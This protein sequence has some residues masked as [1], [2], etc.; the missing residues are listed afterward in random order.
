MGNRAMAKGMSGRTSPWIVA[1]R[2]SR[3]DRPENTRAAF[4]RA[5]SFPI[6]GIELDVQMTKDRVPV[7]FHDRTL[8]KIMEG[9]KRL[10]DFSY[11]ELASLDWGQ[12][13]SRK[14][15]G[16]PLLTLEKALQLY[17]KKTRLFIEIKSRDRDR[18]SGRS[19]VL[20]SRVL[21]LI[22]K[23]VPRKYLKNI[24][25]LSFDSEVLS[26][27]QVKSPR[28]NYV[29]NLNE[30]VSLSGRR[31]LD[32]ETLHAVCVPIR[33]LTPRFTESAHR[34]GLAVMTYACNIP[35]QVNKALALNPDVIMTDK[36]GWLV[37]YLLAQGLG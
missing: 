20:T 25:L 1:H 30:P 15:R 26:L 18:K 6:D 27:A 2:G 32:M 11:A 23:R 35:A 34:R 21:D 13:Y 9:R 12:W 36:P 19:P 22:R 3:S 37:N 31:R 7:L 4:D 24:F 10:D 17:G 28:L 16:E 8:A 14:Y 5:L 33:A 29:F